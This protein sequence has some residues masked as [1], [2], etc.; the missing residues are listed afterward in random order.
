[1]GHPNLNLSEGGRSLATELR[2]YA[3]RRDV[4]VLAL[5]AGTVP[6]AAEVA[7]Q[8][9]AP[10][11]LFLVRPLVVYDRGLLEIGAITSGGVLILDPEA[12][13]AHGIPASSIATAAQTEAREL[14]RRE[15]VYRGGQTPLDLRNRKAIVVD[16][17]H[18]SA[19]LLRAANA[20]LRRRWTDRVILASPTMPAAV[21]RELFREA[22]EIVTAVTDQAT[23]EPA[24]ASDG[25]AISPAKVSRLL[26]R[27]AIA[28]PRAMP[29]YQVA[30]HPVDISHPLAG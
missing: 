28:A 20:A 21:F 22:D 1:M 18:S 11:D 7:Q 29:A 10:I 2:G 15:S 19:S 3:R 24:T 25:T 16:D 26:R 23:D 6:L 12:I 14:D 5:K 30:R 8:L 27:G 9:Q 17:G 4:V 13:K